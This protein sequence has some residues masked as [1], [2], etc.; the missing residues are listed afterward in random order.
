MSAFLV[1]PSAAATWM[2]LRASATSMLV[3]ASLNLRPPAMPPTTAEGIDAPPTPPAL[4]SEK[5]TAG[6]MM[7]SA[8]TICPPPM[9][10]PARL[11]GRREIA[12]LQHVP[13][14]C[15]AFDDDEAVGLLD[16]HPNEPD[17]RRQL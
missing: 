12:L 7:K 1:L 10:D 13:H 4:P 15:A 3:C 17:R 6:V 2:P 16:H 14:P 11:A 5:T 8:A 9:F